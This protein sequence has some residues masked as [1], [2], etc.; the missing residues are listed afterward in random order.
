MARWWRISYSH[1]PWT[2]SVYFKMLSFAQHRTQLCGN[3]VFLVCLL[4]IIIE[5]LTSDSTRR[6]Q[7]Y[8]IDLIDSK[9][10]SF[11]I[12]KFISSTRSHGAQYFNEFAHFVCWTLLYVRQGVWRS[13]AGK[14]RRVFAQNRRAQPTTLILFPPK[15][16]RD[17]CT[18]V[19]CFRNAITTSS[20]ASS[21]SSTSVQQKATK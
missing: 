19:V 1:Q 17:V 16:E 7:A 15:S 8:T 2:H 9:R 14:R 10:G 18:S 6:T 12:R 20:L 11:Y 3:N 13:V 4:N 21:S 5:S